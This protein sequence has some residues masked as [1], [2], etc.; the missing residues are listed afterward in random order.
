MGK[1]NFGFIGILTVL[2]LFVFRMSSSSSDSGSDEEYMSRKKK[3]AKTKRCPRCKKQI[4]A[5][6]LKRHIRDVH[7]KV[8]SFK[9][10][11]CA[12]AFSQKSSLAFHVKSKHEAKIEGSTNYKCFKCDIAFESLDAYD[13]H[14]KVAHPESVTSTTLQCPK[15]PYK[16]NFQSKMKYHTDKRHSE[17]K[18]INP[19]NNSGNSPDKEKSLCTICH[20]TFTRGSDLKR[21]VNTSFYGFVE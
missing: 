20:K 8:K 14:R 21:Y 2:F 16:T 1:S 7:L 17:G 12:E 15:C 13:E 9:C 4:S 11:Q 10:D 18:V 5:K 6:S 3:K 19:A